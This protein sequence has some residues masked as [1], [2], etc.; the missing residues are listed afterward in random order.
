MPAPS[1]GNQANS[2]EP[3]NA[4]SGEAVRQEEHS[5]E[6]KTMPRM[7]LPV[8]RTRRNIGNRD[9]VFGEFDLLTLEL[10]SVLSDIIG[11][12]ATRWP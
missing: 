4:D 10:H 12:V 9:R 8:A 11:D 7:T 6:R 5:S 1:L 3:K 2:G